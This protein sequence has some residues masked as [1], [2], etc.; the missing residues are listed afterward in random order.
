MCDQC[1]CCCVTM[2]QVCACVWFFMVCTCAEECVC[3]HV[4]VY[5]LCL[6]VCVCVCMYVRAR[7]C[8]CVCVCVCVCVSVWCTERGEIDREGERERGEI[9]RGREERLR[10][11]ET[12]TECEASALITLCVAARQSAGQW[13]LR[14]AEV[15]FCTRQALSVGANRD[16]QYEEKL[17]AHEDEN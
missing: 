5:L 8:T 17:A 15:R 14:R 2:Q 1:V 9:E 12:L 11:R 4:C 13:T 10:Q 16:A 7:V 3:V 6:F